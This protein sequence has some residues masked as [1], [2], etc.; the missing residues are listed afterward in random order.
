MHKHDC[1]NLVCS[2]AT[3][4]KMLLNY[5]HIAFAVNL[6]LSFFFSVRKTPKMHDIASE[7]DL[8]IEICNKIIM[9]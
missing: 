2:N 4:R 3:I 5:L 9:Q 6:F 1:N 7:S 8:L